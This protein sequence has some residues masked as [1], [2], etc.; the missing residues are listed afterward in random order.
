MMYK[1]GLPL[2]DLIFKF[3]LCEICD[4]YSSYD[5][6]ALKVPGAAIM[7]AKLTFDVFENFGMPLHT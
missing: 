3:E 7:E 2:P 1:A 6:G 5:S 4:S